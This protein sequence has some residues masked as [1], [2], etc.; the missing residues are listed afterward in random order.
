MCQNSDSSW[1]TLIEHFFRE[2]GGLSFLLNCRYDVKLLNLNNV[3]TT[4]LPC[5][6]KVLARKQPIILEDNTH[7]QNE[8]IW[9]NKNI[10]IDM[11]YLKQWHWT[12]LLYIKINDLLDENFNF[13]SCDKFQQIFQL[14]VPFTAYYGLIS[15]IPPSWR[16]TIKHTE[17]AIENDNVSQEPPL[18]KNFATCAVYAAI[19][20]HY[21]QP[22]TAEPKLL[23]YGFLKECKFITSPLLP[24]S[25]QSSKF[26]NIKLS[27]TYFQLGVPFSIWSYAILKSVSY[28]KCNRKHC[29]TYFTSSVISNFWS[30][31]QNWWFEKHK[32]IITLAERNI[33]FGWHNNTTE[34]KDILNYVTL[35]AKYYVFY[36]IQDSDDVPF[37]GFPSLLKNK[38][39]TSQQIAVKNKPLT[40]STKS[41]KTLFEF[42]HFTYSVKW[43]VNL[44]NS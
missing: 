13:L 7:K 15:T 29:L 33:L 36:T 12:G 5:N 31:F 22:P 18:S 34:S 30:A 39:N 25:K 24:R 20:D 43:L 2:H 6:N 14:H 11:I 28:A 3:H 16:C 35:V 8:I 26:F 32:N 38:L 42:F 44:N 19:I 21:S 27:T 9:N 41:G 40:I 10:L 17:I 4:L 23:Q 1:K 37:D